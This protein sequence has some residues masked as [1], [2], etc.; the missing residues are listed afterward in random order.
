MIYVFLG[1]F[2]FVGGVVIEINLIN[3][4]NLC[5][6]FLILYYVLG[7]FFFVGYFWYVGCVCVVVVGFEKGI[8]C[9]I[10]LVFLMCLFD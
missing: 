4:V 1:L 10:E 8:D 7:F 3:F 9:D 6:W 5:S 2:N